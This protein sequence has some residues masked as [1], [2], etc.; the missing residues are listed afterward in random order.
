[1]LRRDEEQIKSAK[2]LLNK[3]RAI[4][5]EECGTGKTII[6]LLAA[7]ATNLP[8]YVCCQASVIDQWHK[9]AELV[10]LKKDIKVIS[11]NK[12]PK[13]RRTLKGSGVFIVDEVHKM[14]KNWKQSDLLKSVRFFSSKNPYLWL[15]S[16]T[17]SEHR[18]LDF[19]WLLKLVDG[20][21]L[22]KEDFRIKFCGAYYHPYLRSPYGGKLLVDG[23]PTNIK[24]LLGLFDSVSIKNAKR[25]LKVNKKV[26]L[27]PSTGIILPKFEETAKYR[28]SMGHI[29]LS[30]IKKL[31]EKDRQVADNVL[32]FTWHRDI[33]KGLAEFLG[34]KY[35]IGGQSARDRQDAISSGLKE[36]RLVVSLL[37]G[38]VG[39][40][41]LDSFSK[42]IFV[43]L[44]YS[45]A[46]DKQAY[47]RMVRDK[48][49]REIEVV[50]CVT[51]DEHTFMVNNRKKD[52]LVGV[53]VI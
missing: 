47:M 38:G 18:P 19:Y 53:G 14:S 15:L 7:R 50:W 2:E 26:L 34:C 27:F 28:A 48:K 39:L 43:E 17:P 25:K 33:T 5:T 21:R 45:P 51:K 3:G 10:G 12:F 22:S 32:F 8:V 9:E 41:G 52:Y 40:N 4:L 37:A 42:C 44:S 11:Y 16:A 30:Y 36:G 46:T 49:D 6:T 24:E 29:K 31:V 1:M 23:K 13:V 35:I 20:H